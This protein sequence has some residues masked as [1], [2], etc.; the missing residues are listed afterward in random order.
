[1]KFSKGLEYVLKELCS[2][3]NIR[4]E[5]VDFSNPEWFMERTWTSEEQ[6]NFRQWLVNELL[7]NKDVRQSLYGKSTKIPKNIAERIAGMFIL[8]YG[9]KCKTND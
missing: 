4:F 3:V 6:E 8:N 5:D 1:M 2:R 9:W 7:T